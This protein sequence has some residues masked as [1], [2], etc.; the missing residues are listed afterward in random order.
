[1]CL[2]I[3][4][5]KRHWHINVISITFK[6]LKRRIILNERNVSLEITSPITFISS[7]RQ[8][9]FSFKFPNSYKYAS[10]KKKSI[11]TQNVTTIF[12]TL[13]SKVSNNR[14]V[15]FYLAS[16]CLNWEARNNLP[17]SRSTIGMLLSATFE[18]LPSSYLGVLS[19]PR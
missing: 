11:I 2:N 3:S 5:I 13:S 14:K 19:K 6:D 18:K 17:W 1:M 16:V 4:L 15:S 10:G 7:C 12:I 9:I 8:M